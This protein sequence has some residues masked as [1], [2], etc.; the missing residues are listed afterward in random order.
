MTVESLT[1]HRISRAVDQQQ[2]MID[3]RLSDGRLTPERMVEL[4]AEA[5]IDFDTWFRFQKEQSQAHTSQL[6][7][8]DEAQYVYAALNGET[9][10]DSVNGGWAEGVTLAQKVVITQVMS[11]LIA[12]RLRIG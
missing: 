3:E 7:T 10:D 6:L 9:F 5:A 2:F 1:P 8:L 11:E 4:D 12:I